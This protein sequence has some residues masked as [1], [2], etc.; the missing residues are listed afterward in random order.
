MKKYA[1]ALVA[2]GLATPALAQD[3]PSISGPWV[4]ALGGWDHV[5]LTDGSASGTKSGLTYGGA[6]G[7]DQDYGKVVLGVEGELSGSNVRDAA[8]DDAG[9]FAELKAGR[10]L[11]AGLR[12]GFK[13]GPQTMFYGKV[14]Y[15]NARANA[16]YTLGGTTDTASGHLDGYRLGGGVQYTKGH[17]FG[18]L[19]YRYSD[20]GTWLYQGVSTGLSTGRNQVVAV[21]GY[22]F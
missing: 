8:S 21:A 1:I 5:R 15:T 17:M 7:Y 2:L 6:I 20:Y 12:L 10:D 22:R 11:Y 9:N 19:E 16:T 13:V 3:E 14:G 4:A 18:R